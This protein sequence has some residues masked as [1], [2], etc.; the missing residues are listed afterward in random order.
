MCDVNRP[1]ETLLDLS[2]SRSTVDRDAR[3]RAD[4]DTIPQALAAPDTLMLD[5]HGITAAVTGVEL[6][7]DA[8]G[9]RINGNGQ[10]GLVLRSPQEGDAEAT[11]FFL[12]RREGRT[13]LARAHEQERDSEGKATY[14]DVGNA[15][16]LTL[17]DVGAALDDTEAGLFTTAT[18]LAQWHARNQFCPRCGGQTA[19]ELGGW[20]RRC[21][22]DGSEHYPRTDP[23]VIMAVID[24]DDRL[25]L[26]TGVP[27]PAGR[28]SVLAGFVE[29]G[30]S[31]EAAVIRE[32][33]EEIGVVVTDL[34]YRGNQPWPFPASLMLGYTA[35]A[36]STE[37]TL[38][39]TELTSA[40]WYTREELAAKVESGEITLP[41]RVSI[42]RHLIEE[43]FGAPL[44]DPQ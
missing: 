6:T 29:A 23:A 8:W 4:A 44:T 42:A 16:W 32:V 38:D 11:L 13:Y 9:P 18:A 28:V 19:S 41:S 15:H 21:S 22:E 37:L 35:R 5:L 7:D 20:V 12:G 30:E 24:P 3:A 10:A 39:P 1:D 33:A 43:W 26:A 27:W 17:R 2:L 14:P 34:R 40:A 31:L 25:L 36:T